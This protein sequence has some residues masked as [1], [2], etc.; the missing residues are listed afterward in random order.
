ME[1]RGSKTKKVISR[2]FLILFSLLI[3][4]FFIRLINPRQIDDVSPAIQCPELQYYNIKYLYVIPDYNNTPIGNDTQWCNYILSLNKKLEL[5]GITH[6]NREFLYSNISQQQLDFGIS[7]FQECFGYRPEMFKP[8]NLQINSENKKLIKE[9]NLILKNRLNQ[10]TH[11]V[12]H[13]SN[14]GALDNKIIHYF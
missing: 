2:F 6:T 14:R 11:K 5:H 3:V 12:Y 1:K 10:L 4:L 8:P 13:C 7:Q 9:N